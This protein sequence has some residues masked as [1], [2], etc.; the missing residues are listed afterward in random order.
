MI[1]LIALWL[2]FVSVAILF[3]IL[4]E[5]K[6]IAQGRVPL[7]RLRRLWFR[8]ERRR[9]PRFRTNSLVRYRRL[10][11]EEA[12]SASARANDIS[13]TGAGLVVQNYLAA[14]SRL[15]LEF[16]IPGLPNSL[17]VTGQVAWIRPVR[18]RAGGSSDEKLFLIGVQ[19]I[20]MD[21]TIT[22]HFKALFGYTTRG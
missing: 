2:L 21:P 5:E 22:A 1:R 19:F 12:S 16:I 6:L 17:P 7:G 4:R 10:S 11:P 14:G 15:R 18:P 8:N 13:E 3:I 20:G 9:A